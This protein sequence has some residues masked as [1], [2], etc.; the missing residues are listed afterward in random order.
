MDRALSMAV[1]VSLARQLGATHVISVTV[2]SAL[3]CAAPSNMLQ[4]VN[5]C[6]QILQ[7][8]SE[9]GWRDET[10]LVIDPD[11]RGVET[12]MRS[13]ADLN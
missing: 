1:P 3:S 4:L 2:P 7:R 11:V 10:D 5:R 13:A 6:F 12:G 8:R 9:N